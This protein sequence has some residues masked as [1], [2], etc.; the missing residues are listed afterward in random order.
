MPLSTR[1]RGWAAEE[2]PSSPVAAP[3]APEAAP[4][5]AGFLPST[6]RDIRRRAH[7]DAILI[8]EETLNST[9]AASLPPNERSLGRVRQLEVVYHYATAQASRSNHFIKRQRLKPSAEAPQ[10]PG[11]PAAP[12]P[13]SA[14]PAAAGGAVGGAVDGAAADSPAH[15][16]RNTHLA[17]QSGEDGTHGSV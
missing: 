3:S 5:Q 4:P 17:N 1:A 12:P 7:A 2:P 8:S 14:A 16:N 13:P 10:G 11:P 6:S 15:Y 9:H